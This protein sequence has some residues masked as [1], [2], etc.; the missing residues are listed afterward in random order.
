MILVPRWNEE[1]AD[2]CIQR[3]VDTLMLATDGL[4]RH[5]DLRPFS[6]IVAGALVPAEPPV[7]LNEIVIDLEAGGGSD[8]DDAAAEGGDGAVEGLEKQE[9][10]AGSTG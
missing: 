5:T 1:P 10:C 3:F 8:G 2:A 7:D 9:V 6:Q 4:E